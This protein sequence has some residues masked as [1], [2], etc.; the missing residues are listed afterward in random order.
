MVRAFFDSEGSAYNYRNMVRV[1]QDDKLILN[2]LKDILLEFGIKSNKTW[3]YM[4]R[5]KKRYVFDI[6]NK[7]N[8]DKFHNLIG[9]ISD[10]KKLNS[11]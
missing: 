2:E 10:S 4:K 8:F 1:F 5:G 9:F 6:S 3:Y 11:C 7:E